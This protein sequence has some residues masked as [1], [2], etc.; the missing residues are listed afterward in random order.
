MEVPVVSSLSTNRP[1]QDVRQRVQTARIKRRLTVH[2][3]AQRVFCDADQIA[4]FERGEGI[5]S[6]E[7]QKRVFEELHLI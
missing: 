6:D 1:L 5:L 7:I 4:A 3:L 2:E